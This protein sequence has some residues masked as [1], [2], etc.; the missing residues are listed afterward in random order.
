MKAAQKRSGSI[1]THQLSR[2]YRTIIVTI[3]SSFATKAKPC[4]PRSDFT[5]LQ[6]SE[7]IP[8]KHASHGGVCRALT[9]LKHLN[10][11]L[12]LEPKAKKTSHEQQPF[13]AAQVSGHRSSPLILKNHLARHKPPLPTR[14]HACWP[15]SHD[16]LWGMV[17]HLFLPLWSHWGSYYPDLE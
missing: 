10:L 3:G 15:R 14:F 1:H 8:T 13:W 9:N 4:P 2:R 17:R 6:N 16:K 11:I 5:Q 7:D 12:N